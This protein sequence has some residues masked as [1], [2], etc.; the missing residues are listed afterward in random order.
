MFFCLYLKGRVTGR[1]NDSSLQIPASFLIGCRSSAC[2]EQ[3]LLGLT[4]VQ[5]PKGP[6][7]PP[8][9]S[10]SRSWI[11]GRH[12]DGRGLAYE[13]TV[14]SPRSGVRGTET[15]FLQFYPFIKTK[16]FFYLK[17]RKIQISYLLVH[18]SNVLEHRLKPALSRSP[19]SWHRLR[20]LSQHLL[21]PRPGRSWRGSQD[22]TEAP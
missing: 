6:P 21:P 3:E 15:G 17:G 13:T 12:S 22:M 10:L 11:A 14:P 19:C 7:L 2:Q 20:D 8:S 9:Q 5:G 16:F 1:R 4:W 18:S